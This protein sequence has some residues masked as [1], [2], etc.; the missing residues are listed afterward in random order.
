MMR[1]GVAGVL[2]VTVTTLVTSGCM[3][4]RATGSR[5]SGQPGGGVALTLFAEEAFTAFVRDAK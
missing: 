3:S 4:V 2:L 5:A 1:R